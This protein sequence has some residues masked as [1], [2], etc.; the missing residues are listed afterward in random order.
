MARRRSPEN[1]GLPARWRKYHG[2]YYYQVPPA[3]RARWDGKAQFR[4]GTSL[5]DAYAAW[6]ARIG[7]IAK[8]GTIKQ[9][10]ERYALD[11]VPKKAAATQDGNHRI[12][13]T[14]TRKIGDNPLT[15]VT[16][17]TIY[18]YIDRRLGPT[19]KPALTAAHREIEVLSHA[20]TKAVEW[21]IIK[22][23]P[24]KDQVRLDGDR[25]LRTKTRYVEDAE[26][27]AALTLKPFRKRGSVR[28]CQAYIRLKLAT[29]MRQ[30]DLLLLQPGR[31]D[32]PDGIR[33]RPS[34]TKRTT[35]KELLFRWTLERRAAWDACLAARPVD[36]APWLFCTDDGGC[37]LG[38]NGK[39]SSFESVWHRFM[40][41]LLAEKL[42]ATRFT[43]RSIRAKYA[44]DAE[45]M[46]E[47]QR[48]L[49]HADPAV[50]KKHYRLKP[51]VI[52]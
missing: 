6:A 15:V 7:R 27:A 5:P 13:A 34:K 48:K 43:E 29:G 44:S 30:T 31:S 42:I 46:E 9:L 22:R 21:G 20:F 17:Q 33:I 18:A 16:P 11:V 41:R 3:E 45:T 24:F 49:G 36:I 52:E 14:L 1:W 25:A 26:V 19:G 40:D 37:Y 35:G 4:L 10:L 32:M 50:T 12:I 38:E 23:H 39:A 51:E 47:A 28:M 2:A 8:V